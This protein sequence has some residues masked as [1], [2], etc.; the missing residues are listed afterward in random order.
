MI[1]ARDPSAGVTAEGCVFVS[2]GTTITEG[3][4]SIR[5]LSSNVEHRGHIYCTVSA[6]QRSSIA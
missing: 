2:G 1:V 4:S 5:R 6:W 3:P